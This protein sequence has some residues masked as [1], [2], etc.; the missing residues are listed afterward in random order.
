MAK[1]RFN[2][3]EYKGLKHRLQ[4]LQSRVELDKGPE[5]ETAVRLLE[6]IKKKLK[7]YE[8]TH[9]IPEFVDSDTMSETATVKTT[10]S[11]SY[12]EFWET[13]EAYENEGTKSA[14]SQTTEK[15]QM[16][17]EETRTEERLVRDLGVLYTIFGSTYCTLLNYRTFKIRF[18][19][20]IEKQEA[21][22][23]VIADI[24]EDD[25]CIAKGV[26]IGFWPFRFG[27]TRCGDMQFAIWS[28]SAVTKY[29]DGC[30]WLYLT[31][32]DELKE[33][34][35]DYFDNNTLLLTGG[36]EGFLGTSRKNEVKV[37]LTKEQRRRI[38]QEVE[39]NC[40]SL[41]LGGYN[42][43]YSD[44]LYF[45]SYVT[46]KDLNDLLE[47]SGVVYKVEPDGVYILNFFK[48]EFQRLLE[49]TREGYGYTLYVQY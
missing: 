15:Q 29:N 9:E 31:L 24:Y 5:H 35:N 44:Q 43:Y 49:Y 16:Y 36:I 21:F 41:K 3:E 34:W 1:L 46:Y 30:I 12:K 45:H 23:R 14:F 32:L 2:K 17:Q 18:Q 6:Q 48:K 26:L 20:Q 7:N 33:I 8:E 39:F 10:T 38:I 37:Q 19:N 28:S 13:Y 27:D 25:I 22:Y 47:R 40:K 42:N 4:K 11:N